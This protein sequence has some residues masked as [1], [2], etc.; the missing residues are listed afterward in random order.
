LNTNVQER[1]Y[2]GHK[3]RVCT[4][5]ACSNVSVE[6]EFVSDAPQPGYSNIN[7]GVRLGRRG[8]I[9]MGSSNYN[10]GYYGGYN[11]YSNGYNTINAYGYPVWVP[12]R[13]GCLGR[14]W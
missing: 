5:G 8:Y 4:N 7:V 12:G 10:N 11:G 14:C 1:S 2:F 13:P 9:Q 3:Q 6:D